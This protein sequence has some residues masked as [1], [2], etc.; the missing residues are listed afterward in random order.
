MPDFEGYSKAYKNKRE[1]IKMYNPLFNNKKPEATKIVASTIKASKC[2][3]YSVTFDAS[4]N[5]VL[6]VEEE[7]K[8]QE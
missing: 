5:L 3:G 7:N 8:E 6:P 1:D 4:K 2:N